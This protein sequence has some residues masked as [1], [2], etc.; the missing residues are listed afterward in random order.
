[1]PNYIIFLRS[2][3]AKKLETDAS[4]SEISAAIA[5]FRPLRDNLRALVDLLDTHVAGLEARKKTPCSNAKDK[6]L[7]IEVLGRVF[8]AAVSQDMDG[9]MLAKIVSHVSRNFRNAAIS[10]P[11]L[12]STLSNSQTKEEIKAFLSRSATAGLTIL[13]NE[14]PYRDYTM[15][16]RLKLG[17]FFE[18]VIPHFS[19]V[20]EF[21]FTR[22]TATWDDYDESA[23]YELANVP[24]PRM[25]RMSLDGGDYSEFGEGT[26]YFDL[27]SI[28]QWKGPSLT[29]LVAVNSIPG[30]TGFRSIEKLTLTLSTPEE[31]IWG[32]DQLLSNSLC[33]LAKLRSLNLTFQNVECLSNRYKNATLPALERLALTFIGPNSAAA[34]RKFFNALAYPAVTEVSITFRD[35]GSGEQMPE[36]VGLKGEL[37]DEEE[38]CATLQRVEQKSG[39]VRLWDALPDEEKCPTLQHLYLHLDGKAYRPDLLSKIFGLLPQLHHLSLEAPKLSSLQI[40]GNAGSPCPEEL[41][42]LTFVRCCSLNPRAIDAVVGHLQRSRGWRTFQKLELQ[43]CGRLAT[44]VRQKHGAVLKDKLV[45]NA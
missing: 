8:K 6:A 30:L 29:T 3:P 20:E 18:L 42:T 23:M 31:G 1:M 2:R 19:R 41:E 21:R 12:W 9:I 7:P 39:P 5:K 36:S 44:S 35:E 15:K 38:R 40:D 14:D 17:E 34:F 43:G 16:S 25:V 11:V 26:E 22:E 32:L 37:S 4:G 33:H 24:A 27:F 10:T 28:S 45:T 13:V